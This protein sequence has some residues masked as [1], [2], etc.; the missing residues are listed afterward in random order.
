MTDGVCTGADDG[1]GTPCVGNGP[2]ATA[3]NVQG[4]DC[5]YAPTDIIISARVSMPAGT[6]L[7]FTNVCVD[8]A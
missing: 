2:Q 8:N 6:A 3:C 1:T 7:T 4:G 5:V